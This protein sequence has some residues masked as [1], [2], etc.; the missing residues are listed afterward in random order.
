[1]STFGGT[2]HGGTGADVIV[3]FRGSS[4]AL[5]GGGGDDSLTSP[6]P[7]SMLGGPGNDR[8][9][10]DLGSRQ[11]SDHLTLDGGDGTDT[12]VLDGSKNT[13]A[14][15]VD[16]DLGKGTLAVGPVKTS[17]RAFEDF[18][19]RFGVWSPR[20]VYDVTGTDGPNAIALGGI[21]SSTVWALGGD[22][23]VLGSATGNDDIVGGPGNDTA[24][25]RGGT[26]T[27]WSVEQLSNCRPGSPDDLP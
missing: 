15:T 18:Q 19:G 8:L 17:A 4:T 9:S 26:D 6:G 5:D 25:G 13:V 27:C 20:T 21:G 3:A 14:R 1:L 23:L 24:D 10:I 22:D 7:G 11:L 16:L 12:L 2:V